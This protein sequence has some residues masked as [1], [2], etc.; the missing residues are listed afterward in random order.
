[1][2]VLIDGSCNFL[3]IRGAVLNLA[4]ETHS[5]GNSQKTLFLQGWT[6]D[7]VRE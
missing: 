4:N 1:M 2:L 5:K 6:K 3:E 7:L